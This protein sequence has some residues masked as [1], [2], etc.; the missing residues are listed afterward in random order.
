MIA[1]SMLSKCPGLRFREVIFFLFHIK[2]KCHFQIIL[3]WN[4]TVIEEDCEV[5]LRFLSQQPPG[6]YVECNQLQ[7][8]IKP[9]TYKICHLRGLPPGHMSLTRRGRKLELKSC[10][11]VKLQHKHKLIAETKYHCFFIN[12]YAIFSLKYTQKWDREKHR[13]NDI[14]TSTA[15]FKL[16]TIVKNLEK[17]FLCKDIVFGI[18]SCFIKPAMISIRRSKFYFMH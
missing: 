3:N 17:I 9:V 8:R 16:G 12:V 4:S 6:K 18:G 7:S 5:S 14:T 2:N 1:E 15:S 13:E 10:L 11:L